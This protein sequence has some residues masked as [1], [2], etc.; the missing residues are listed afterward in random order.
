[1][2]GVTATRNSAHTIKK[3]TGP[4]VAATTGSMP[5]T[6]L[7]NVSRYGRIIKIARPMT[8]S[9]TGT[10]PFNS[11]QTPPPRAEYVFTT[12]IPRNMAEKTGRSHML[13][14]ASPPSASAVAV[15]ARQ[16]QMPRP[17]RNR[18]GDIRKLQA[19]ARNKITNGRDMT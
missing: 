16:L 8:V 3:C 12:T 13:V 10:D 6:W 9:P 19:K 14:N 11:V 17:P 18:T 5:D 4:V 15:M 7:L 1:M 2:K